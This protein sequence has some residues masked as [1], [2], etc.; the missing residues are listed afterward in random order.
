MV[1]F[2]NYNFIKKGEKASFLNSKSINT[3]LTSPILT[4]RS[5][6][7]Q[8]IYTR[9]HSFYH[10]KNGAAPAVDI[11]AKAKNSHCM[12]KILSTNGAWHIGIALV[13]IMAGIF[14]FRYGRELFNIDDLLKFLTD[15][16]WPLPVFSGYTA[17][18]IELAGGVLLALGLFTRIVCVLLMIVMLGVTFTMGGGDPFNSEGASLFFLLFANFCFAGP[19]KLSLDYLLFDRKHES[20]RIKT[21]AREFV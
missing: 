15:V 9:L 14:I 8:R 4:L 21:N 11:L 19:G 20:T 6:D 17:K 18:I 2:L 3:Y 5:I 10:S 13:R 12:Q 1:A 16:K 7:L